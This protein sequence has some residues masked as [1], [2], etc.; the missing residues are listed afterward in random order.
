MELDNF[1]YK[2][3]VHARDGGMGKDEI[4]ETTKEN[5]PDS[6]HDNAIAIV[7][8]LDFDVKQ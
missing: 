7:N 5:L 8:N 4:L 6:L 1:I 3:I 2:A